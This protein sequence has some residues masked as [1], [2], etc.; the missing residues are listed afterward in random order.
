[1]SIE[2]NSFL[3]YN[4][5]QKNLHVVNNLSVSFHEIIDTDSKLIF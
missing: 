2:K 1:M 5:I 4:I 3:S